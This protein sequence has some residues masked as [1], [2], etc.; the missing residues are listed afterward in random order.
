MKTKAIAA[1]A[2][3][4]ATGSAMAYPSHHQ[5]YSFSFIGNE[6]NV[7]NLVGIF[8][9]VGIRGCVTVDNTGNAV[10]QSSQMVD[11]HGVHLTGP[12]LGSYVTGD[13]TYGV[14]SKTTTV[15]NQGSAYL[16]AGSTRTSFDNTTSW[17]NAEA[18]GHLNTSQ[19]FQAGAGYIAGQS[20]SGSGSFIAGGGYEYSNIAGGFGAIGGG[21]FW[22]PGGGGVYGGYLFGNFGAGQGA[23]WGGYAYQQ[24]SQE[25]AGFLAAGFLNTQKSFDAGFHGLFNEGQASVHSESIAAGALWGFSDTYMKS[26]TWVHGAITYHINTAQYQTM[27]ATLGNGALANANGNIGV[28]VAAGADNAQANNVAIASLNAQPVYASAQVFANQ[29]SKGSA[30]ISQFYVTSSV[31]DNALAGATGN[32]G[33]NVAAGVGNVQQNGLAAAVSQSG[34]GW[35]KGGAANSTAQTDQSA[36]MHASGD[37]IANASLGNG[38]LSWASGNIGVNVASGIGNVQSNSLA[39]SAIK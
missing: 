25:A 8:G 20:H 1:A 18:N 29:S 33:V 38:A 3:L 7:L 9:L 15:S 28:N 17:V 34:Y 14:H 12:L 13:V 10:V 5:Q 19:S 6:T 39:V 23:A 21:H 31:G 37:F 24:Q 2:L 30:S 16:L 11:A 26:T 32:V 27:G 36:S 35:Y 4:V 22:L